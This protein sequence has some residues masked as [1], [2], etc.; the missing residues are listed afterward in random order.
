MK[1]FIS[2]FDGFQWKLEHIVRFANSTER[3]SGE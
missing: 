3:L 1:S 2:K